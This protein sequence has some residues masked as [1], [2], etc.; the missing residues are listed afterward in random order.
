LLDELTRVEAPGKEWFTVLDLCKK[1][2]SRSAAAYRLG[3]L[4]AEGKVERKQF[5]VLN[6]NGRR[7]KIWYYRM[8]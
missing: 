1:G 5:T 6:W 8:K 2:I 3:V 4:L 7:A